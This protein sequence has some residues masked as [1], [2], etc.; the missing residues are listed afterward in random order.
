M[1][2]QQAQPLWLVRALERIADS[3]AGMKVGS[4]IHLLEMALK[5][6]AELLER[7]EIKAEAGLCQMTFGGARACLQDIRKIAKEEL[8]ASQ[9]SS[10]IA[11]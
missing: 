6:R 9:L 8:V 10:R 1:S 11:P 4:D 3:S 2:A 5:D 7:I